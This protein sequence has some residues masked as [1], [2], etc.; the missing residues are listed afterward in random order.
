MAGG[1]ILTI[2]FFV[3]L[4]YFLALNLY[5]LVLILIGLFQ[6]RRIALE[7]KEEGYSA[8]AH[9][10]FTVPV[11]IIV[12]AHNEEQY[13]A[14]CVQSL[15][16]LKYPEFE[17]IIVNDTSSDDTFRILDG[18]LQL[19]SIDKSYRHEFRDG[20]I[21]GVYISTR[22]PNVSVI[23]KSGLRKAGALN[24]GLNFAHY[25]Y[26]C[27][28][29]ADTVL[30]P[31][32][33]LKVMAHIQK[34]PEKIIGAGSYFGLLNGLK[35]KDGKIVQRSFSYNPI[36][37]YQNLEYIRSFAGMRITWSRFNA[38]PVISGGFG[39][40]RRD[41]LFELGGYDP[42]FTC[43]DIELTFRAHDYNVKKG[44][45]YTIMSLPDYVGWTE[46][47]GTIKSL[48][49]QRNRWQRVTDE[50]VK[51]YKHML[52]NPKYR[53]FAFLTFPYFLFYEALGILFEL[54]SIGIVAWAW[55]V[56]ILNIKIFLALL[57]LM[58]VSQTFISVLVLFVF[59]QDQ[60]IF[61]LRYSLYLLLLSFFEFFL[62]RWIITVAKA[63]G[64]FDYLR[65]VKTFDQYKR[66][67]KPRH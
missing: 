27:N 35:I 50:T 22:Y 41:M 25:K 63:Q 1:Y 21:H 66:Y 67:I 24:A 43:E 3:F 23:N 61:R 52:F 54:T 53:W 51:R 2:T 39:V 33:L 11:S 29:D 16:N 57:A 65:G 19:K 40:W 17:I 46:G 38:M 13:I 31:D 30:E 44:K 58:A 56:G 6:N 18:I 34:N 26:I 4:G 14:N 7:A 36:V 47:P 48:I 59:L 64:T 12:P 60:K 8:L 10:T 5:Y 49:I 9:S 45:D 62:Y 42:D 32:A 15:L 55:L 20:K 28:I 37:A